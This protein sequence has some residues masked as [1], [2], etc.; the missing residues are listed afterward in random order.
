MIE[1][2]PSPP[3]LW[4]ADT[5]PLLADLAV[6]GAPVA[7]DDVARCVEALSQRAADLG[8]PSFSATSLLVDLVVQTEFEAAWVTAISAVLDGLLQR[9]PQAF[10]HTV[11][12][13]ENHRD[14]KGRLSEAAPVWNE[15]AAWLARQ[16]ERALRP[17]D[18]AP[19]GVRL[20]H[21]PGTVADTAGRW[22]YLNT[23]D[24]LFH[25]GH[26]AMEDLNAL[27]DGVLAA[28][29]ATGL[30][31][32]FWNTDHPER[33]SEALGTQVDKRRLLRAA[34]VEEHSGAALPPLTQNDDGRRR[35]RM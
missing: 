22:L 13:V 34:G 26:L 19:A 21:L 17:L 31:T 8:H 2:Y 15:V 32:P 14:G 33:L 7:V 5:R 35:T 1:A 29:Y 10:W 4:V 23:L 28:L 9:D 12:C 16:G 6:R 27:P 11:A 30:D 18:T 3:P 24:V 25:Q 20:A